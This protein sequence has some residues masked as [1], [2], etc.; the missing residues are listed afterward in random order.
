MGTE[1]V[2]GEQWYVYQKARGLKH[3]DCKQVRAVRSWHSHPGSLTAFVWQRAETEEMWEAGTDVFFDYG[4]CAIEIFTCVLCECRSCVR[5][6]CA[7]C[8]TTG[9]LKLVRL[10]YHTTCWH[11]EIVG[12]T[13]SHPVECVDERTDNTQRSCK[14]MLLL[15]YFMVKGSH[16]FFLFKQHQVCVCIYV[17]GP[18]STWENMAKINIC[19][20]VMCKLLGNLNVADEKQLSVAGGIWSYWEKAQRRLP[21]L[22]PPPASGFLWLHSIQ[23]QGFWSL[24]FASS[25]LS[26]LFPLARLI[27][28]RVFTE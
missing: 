28:H 4:F 2:L 19:R 13:K 18:R 11:A 23:N 26:H 5:S 10:L 15:L 9:S 8:W 17:G 27:I 14:C 24:S 20:W 6:V 21:W 12:Q 25:F 7:S 1:G 3:E 22:F 16:F